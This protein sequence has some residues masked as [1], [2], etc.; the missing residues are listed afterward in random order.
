MQPPAR[1]KD[2]DMA[3]AT[4]RTR[5]SRVRNHRNNQLSALANNRDG[6]APLLFR[7]T[8]GTVEAERERVLAETADNVVRHPMF[9]SL[10]ENRA[11]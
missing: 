4:H 6:R 9:A 1:R 7:C 8:A 5:G 11:T 3:L 2:G 10:H